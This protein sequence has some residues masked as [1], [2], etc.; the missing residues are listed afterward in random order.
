MREGDKFELLLSD[1]L[2]PN[3]A[4]VEEIPGYKAMKELGRRADEFEY[5][6]H[7]KIFKYAQEKS[8]A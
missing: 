7:G 8:K 5:I 4:E 6:M 3:D 1:R 2:N